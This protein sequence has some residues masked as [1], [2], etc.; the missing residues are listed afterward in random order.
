MTVVGLELLQGH[1]CNG[2][3]KVVGVVGE[4]MEV[5]GK[6]QERIGG[7]IMRE[8]REGGKEES[9]EGEKRKKWSGR[10]QE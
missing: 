10:R 7:R 1:V 3:R 4:K 9:R 5:K 6:E 2:W 8:E